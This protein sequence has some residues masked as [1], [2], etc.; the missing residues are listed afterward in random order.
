MALTK[1]D[2]AVV[3]RVFA[4]LS[5]VVALVLL[6]AGAVLWNTGTAVTKQVSKSLAEE[7]VYFPPQGSPAFVPE[8]FPNLQQY[9]GQLVDDG[10]KVKAYA[11]DYLAKQIKQVGGGK[12][13]SEVSAAAMMDPQNSALQQQQQMMFQLGTSRSLLLGNGYG[14]WM[15]GEALKKVAVIAFAAA[16]ILVIATGWQVMRY[17]KLQ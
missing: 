2:K 7:K 1:K 12:T 8:A 6:A 17:K 14:A 5:A 10:P 4:C 15:Q 11:D 16:G 9:A 3:A 13:L